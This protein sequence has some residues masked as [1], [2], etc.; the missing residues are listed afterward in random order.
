MVRV[1]ITSHS[2]YWVS[3]DVCTKVVARE[4]QRTLKDHPAH[5]AYLTGG[6]IR[7]SFNFEPS[8]RRAPVA[9][10]H[11]C[12]ATDGGTV[13]SSAVERVFEIHDG[14]PEARTELGYDDD[15]ISS[16]CGR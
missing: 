13:V 6:F 10:E 9:G 4:G 8:F 3:E 11:L 14:T 15:A 12:F 16:S 2:I 1:F 7:Q 5:G